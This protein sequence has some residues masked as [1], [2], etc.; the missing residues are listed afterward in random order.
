MIEISTIEKIKQLLT[1]NLSPTFLEITDQS[2]QHAGHIGNTGGGHYTV[3]ISSPLFSG[4]S[5]L[6]SHRKI[7]TILDVLMKHDIHALKIIL[8]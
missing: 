4:Q 6:T 7:Y 1:T 5:R 2:A 8:K 3:I